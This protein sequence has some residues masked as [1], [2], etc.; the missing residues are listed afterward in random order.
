MEQEIQEK[1]LAL[2]RDKFNLYHSYCI[3]DLLLND[4]VDSQ[5][6]VNKVK[7]MQE[8]EKNDIDEYDNP[9]LILRNGN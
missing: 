9:E 1:L 8:A 5:T 6:F 2:L 7:E 4:E 3:L